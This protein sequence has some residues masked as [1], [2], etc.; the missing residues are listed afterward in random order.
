MCRETMSSEVK[1]LVDVACT[2]GSADE[3]SSSNY[4]ALQDSMVMAAVNSDSSDTECQT[5][6]PNRRLI[7]DT[8]TSARTTT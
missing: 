4:G 5:D 6:E 2:E 3:S 1:G 7:A 8:D